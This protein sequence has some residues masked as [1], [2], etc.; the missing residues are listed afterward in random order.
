[1]TSAGGRGSGTSQRWV[2]AIET[3]KGQCENRFRRDPL[4]LA[5]PEFDGV[6]P[7]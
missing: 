7:H 2:L 6:E 5:T 1:M 4:D 3:G